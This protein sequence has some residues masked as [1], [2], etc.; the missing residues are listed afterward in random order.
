MQWPK[1]MG[2]AHRPKKNQLIATASKEA[3]GRN[4][5]RAMVGAWLLDKYC[6]IKKPHRKWRCGFFIVTTAL[7]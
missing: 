2:L 5:W 6:P 7:F 4:A 1:K 3:H